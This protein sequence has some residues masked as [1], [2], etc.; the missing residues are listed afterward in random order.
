MKRVISLLI[1]AVLFMTACGENFEVPENGEYYCQELDL[2]LSFP[3]NEG[4][5][6]K[7][8]VDY[9]VQFAIDDDAVIKIWHYGNK[10]DVILSGNYG[11]KNSVI[12]VS[13]EDKQIYSFLK[14]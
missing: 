11:F 1:I 10:S 7:D 13:T 14:K 4:T 8:K 6:V 5:Y 12:T 3:K 9:Y 2:T